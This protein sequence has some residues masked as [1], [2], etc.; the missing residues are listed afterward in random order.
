MQKWFSA[1]SLGSKLTHWLKLLSLDSPGVEKHGGGDSG[2]TQSKRVAPPVRDVRCFNMA[3]ECLCASEQS[4][5]PQ[6]GKYAHLM[7]SK[8]RWR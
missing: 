3:P 2:E 1:R 7:F 5:K 8:G 6:P 4:W